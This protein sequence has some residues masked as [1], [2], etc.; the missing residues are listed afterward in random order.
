MDWSNGG[1]K[2][3]SIDDDGDVLNVRKLLNDSVWAMSS[4][5]PIPGK[6][7]FLFIPFHVG[8]W[9]VM[10][11]KTATMKMISKDDMSEEEGLLC[12]FT[13]NNQMYGVTRRYADFYGYD[14]IIQY[15]LHLASSGDDI[16][17]YE[18]SFCSLTLDK[19]ETVYLRSQYA[20]D[21]KDNDPI[22]HILQATD[23]D[24]MC[25]VCKSAYKPK[26][27]TSTEAG[28]TLSPGQYEFFFTG[29]DDPLQEKTLLLYVDEANNRTH[30]AL[31][32]NF[33][34]PLS[35][36]S[37]AQ[38]AS[39]GSQYMHFYGPEI[40][41]MT[42]DNGKMTGY[43]VSEEGILWS[44]M[45]DPEKR[46]YSSKTVKLPEDFPKGDIY[47]DGVAYE[48]MGN[49]AFCI[50]SLETLQKEIVP[51]VISQLPE[52]IVGYSEWLFDSGNLLFVVNARTLNGDYITIYVPVTGE[53]RGVARVSVSE[54]GGAGDN[55]S[56]LIRLN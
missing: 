44:V 15:W 39:W 29:H 43:R 11:P 18:N 3:Y 25:F 53:N 49:D 4:V 23:D 56:Q 50:Y 45:L 31:P 54:T 52:D 19:E 21:S 41:T 51:I 22:Y 38:T 16:F 42:S 2:L 35:V 14:N 20:Y 40:Y 55:V 24:P 8:T 28:I 46:E 5:E 32:M 12:F 7:A 47:W 34:Y 6:E 26:T 10:F 13:V 30:D 27:G 33:I 1:S 36:D 9:V 48:M 37:G 17:L